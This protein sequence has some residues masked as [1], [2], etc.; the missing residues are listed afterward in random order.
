MAE[1][2][3]DEGDEVVGGDVERRGAAGAGGVRAEL[4]D[5]AEAPDEQPVPGAAHA[6]PPQRRGHGAR[7]HTRRDSASSRHHVAS[8][9]AS[10]HP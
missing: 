6:L 1:L 9:A 5:V 3:L 10:A 8:T 2:R 7:R 4:V